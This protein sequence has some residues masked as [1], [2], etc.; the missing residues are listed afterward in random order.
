[1][2]ENCCNRDHQIIKLKMKKNRRKRIQPD[3]FFLSFLGTSL[4]CHATSIF[5]LDCTWTSSMKVMT[6]LCTE[7]RLL[8]AVSLARQSRS[9]SMQILWDF[10]R[11]CCTKLIW[12]I[13]RSMNDNFIIIIYW[14][15]VVVICI[16]VCICIN[17]YLLPGSDSERCRSIGHDLSRYHTSGVRR[18]GSVRFP[19]LLLFI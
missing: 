13:F 9:L 4:G 10:G 5:R 14:N 15:S 18:Y 2:W 7:R 8:L 6:I 11:Q 16:C 3:L 12:G 19:Q 17:C 1:M